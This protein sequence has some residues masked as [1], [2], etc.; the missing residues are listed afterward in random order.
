MMRWDDSQLIERACAAKTRFMSSTA[1]KR[2]YRLGKRAEKK[3]ETRLRIVEAAV[4]LHCTLG[5]A[6]TTVSQI[7][8]RAGVQRHTYYAHFPDERS[9]FLACSSLALERGPLPDVEQLSTFPPGSDR[10]RHG[11][12]LFYRWFEQNAG[13]AACVLRDAE[14]HALT[15]QM[16]DL[17]I[18]PVFARAREIMAGDLPERSRALL[19][20]ALDFA[21]WK[22]LSQTCS[23]PEAAALMSDAIAA[24]A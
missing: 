4:D 10:V 9:L 21:C 11:L 13:H 12:E 2:D 14:H 24:L 17:R 8:E 6:R 18:S 3:E 1:K 7:A 19:A 5:P 20:V 22:R 23:T 16:V 15:R